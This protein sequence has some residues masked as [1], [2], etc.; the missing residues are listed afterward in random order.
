VPEGSRVP[1][2]Y[3]CQPDLALQARAEALGLPSVASLSP[4]ERTSLYLRLRPTFTTPWYGDPGYAQLDRRCAVEIREGA[5]D[6]SEMGAL[7]DVYGPQRERN[8]RARLDEYLRFG[9][10]AGIFYE[11]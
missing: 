9:L 1:R 7:H 2:R 5:D 6:R 10:E 3:R 8:L 11:T 4:A